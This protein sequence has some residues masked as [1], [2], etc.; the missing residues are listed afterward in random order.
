MKYSLFVLFF[1]FSVFGG[2]TLKDRVYGVLPA[3]L[4]DFK[5]DKTTLSEVEKKLGKAQLVE[6]QKYYWEKDGLKYALQLSFNNKFVLDSIH[7]TFVT[8]KPAMEKL[9][10]IDAK[11]LAPY[12]DSGRFLKLSEKDVEVLIDP[13]TKKIYSVKLP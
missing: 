4:S 6:G 11:N 13:G 3:P 12:P 2:V 5:T 1:S 9:G 8:E 7:Y 10:K